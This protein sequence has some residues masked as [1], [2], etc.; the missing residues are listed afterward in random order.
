VEVHIRGP[1]SGPG[2]ESDQDR[3]PAMCHAHAHGSMREESGLGI[4]CCRESLS[5]VAPLTKFRTC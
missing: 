4:D 3:R 2:S 5:S 1:E